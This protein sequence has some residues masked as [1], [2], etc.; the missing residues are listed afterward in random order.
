[1][2]MMCHGSVDDGGW[3]LIRLSTSFWGRSNGRERTSCVW[4]VKTGRSASW[5]CPAGGF[6]LKNIPSCSLGFW[7]YS[8]SWIFLGVLLTGCVFRHLCICE[9]CQE[10][11][12]THRNTCPICRFGPIS[13]LNLSLLILSS[14]RKGVKQM[15]KA[16]LWQISGLT[17]KLQE[18]RQ[19]IDL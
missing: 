6:F 4:F 3:K 19:I 13:L 16:Y 9:N 15:I 12:R 1:M 5:S 17:R 10:P 2:L 14:L 7:L 8:E 18:T 11:L